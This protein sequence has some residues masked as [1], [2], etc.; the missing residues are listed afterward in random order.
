MVAVL[1]GCRVTLVLHEWTALHPL[2][3]LIATPYVL[4]SNIIILLSPFIREQ[5]ERDPMLGRA[6]LKCHLIPH[7]PTIYRPKVLKV[8]PLVQRVAEVAQNSD[9]LIGHFGT[10]YRGKA[11]I[12]L[13][14]ICAQLRG[15]GIRAS[16][17]FI[18]ALTSS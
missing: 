3:R 2:R 4:F 17:V 13:L 15:R 14:D 7:P 11:S 8:T 18:G 6:A 1:S 12:E 16:L 10:L 9:I 5:I